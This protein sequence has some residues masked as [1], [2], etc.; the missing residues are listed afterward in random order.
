MNT[1]QLGLLAAGLGAMLTGA[2]VVAE[3]DTTPFTWGADV[4]LRQTWVDNVGHTA[5]SATADRT[6]QRYRAR[7]WGTYAFNDHLHASARLLWEGRHYDEPTRTDM[8]TLETW[9][10]GGVL[11]D[12]LMIQLDQLGGLPLQIKL[13]R[14]DIRLGNG[15]LVFD[16]TPL[17]GA[18][19]IYFDAIRATYTLESHGTTL[20]FIYID[21][22]ADT[23]R[24]PQPLDNDIEDQIE[25]HETGFILYGRNSTLLPDTTLDAYALYKHNRVSDT[26]NTLRRNNGMIFPSPS[27]RGD[28]YAAGVRAEAKLTPNWALRAESVYEWGTRNDRDLRAFGLNSR[29]TYSFKDALK[30]QVHVDLEYLSGDDPDSA[31]DEAFDPLWGRWTQW[32]ELLIYHWNLDARGGEATN[33]QRLNLGWIAQVHPTTQLLLDYH[34]L[35]ADELSTRVTAQQPNLSGDNDF[36]GHLITAWLKS[37]FSPHVSGHLGAEYFMPGHYYADTRQDDSFFV[38]AEVVL[39]W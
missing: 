29:L 21:Q 6:F 20:D 24:F 38:R 2:G 36:R 15:W 25:Q 23:D 26:P 12:Q 3:S 7:L 5:D 39:T 35:W 10:S 8:P 17:D 19:S 31:E 30:N 37:T 11:L 1:Q 14:Q 28:I 18:R 22:N 4:R 32:N 16:G 13:G 33:L 34:A 9:Y 27:D